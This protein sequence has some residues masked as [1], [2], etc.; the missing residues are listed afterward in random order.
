MKEPNLPKG[1]KGGYYFI[2]LAKLM[3]F[4][5]NLARMNKV[6]EDQLNDDAG[7]VINPI[8]VEK[9]RRMEEMLA[10]NRD[11]LWKIYT[12]LQNNTIELT[13]QEVY[14]LL[15]DLA[16]DAISAGEQ[17]GGRIYL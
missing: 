11:L 10:A 5:G 6:I 2:S 9:K 7:P 15:G 3:G 16:E 4:Y 17:E 14:E 8:P 13:K 12:F 1:P